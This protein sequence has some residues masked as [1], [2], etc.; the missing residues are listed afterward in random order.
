MDA[1][2]FDE[3]EF[4]D[5]FLADLAGNAYTCSVMLSILCSIFIEVE[6]HKENECSHDSNIIDALGALRGSDE[7]E[8]PDDGDS[9]DA[10]ND[11]ADSDDASVEPAWVSWGAIGPE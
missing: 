10:D 11:D 9:D 6:W 5:R 7:G 8:D 4:T 1:A 2:A 3:C